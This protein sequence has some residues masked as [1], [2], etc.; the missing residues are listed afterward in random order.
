MRTAGICRK[1]GFCALL[2]GLDDFLT[3]THTY[4]LVFNLLQQKRMTVEN[5]N[6]NFVL[7]TRVMIF[8]GVRTYKRNYK[9]VSFQNCIVSRKAI[10]ETAL[11]TIKEYIIRLVYLI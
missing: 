3:L 1:M 10:K 11:K 5:N 9:I 7:C 4:N 2:L 8:Y 6:Y